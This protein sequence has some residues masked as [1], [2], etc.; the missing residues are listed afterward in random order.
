MEKV[1]NVYSTTIKILDHKYVESVITVKSMIYYNLL[2]S[3]L[4]L[5]PDILFLSAT[6]SITCKKN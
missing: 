3:L 2:Q 1:L 6:S 4:L 5:P